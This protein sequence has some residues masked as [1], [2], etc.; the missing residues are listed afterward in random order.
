MHFEKY[1]KDE[2]MRMAYPDAKDG[3]CPKRP[4][5]GIVFNFIITHSRGLV[6]QVKHTSEVL[7]LLFVNSLDLVN[8]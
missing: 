7:G 3:F 6:S 5:L 4:T 2:Y 1:F 8:C